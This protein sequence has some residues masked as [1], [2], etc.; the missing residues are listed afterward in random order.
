MVAQREQRPDRL[1]LVGAARELDR[2]LEVLARLGG[3]ADAAED[4]PEDAMRAAGRARLAEALR[5]P[6]RLLGRV[7]GE[8]VVARV[9]V[10]PRR[11]LV[12]A[13]ELEAGRAVLQQVR[14]LLVVVERLL[15]VALVPQRSADLAVEV[16]H[17]PQV[18]L[19]AV[20]LEALLPDLDRGVDAAHAERDVALL[21]VDA[22]E[23]L[24]VVRVLDVARGLVVL[25]GLGVRVQERRSVARG[26]EEVQRLA[27]ERLELELRKAGLLREDRGA[28]VVLGQHRDHLVGAVA[29]A[30][31]DEAPDL[32]VLSAAHRLREHPV[33][34]VADEHVLEG[35]LL[36]TRQL[37]AH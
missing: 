6:Q 12:E 28:A 2:P 22:R 11:L 5:E 26:L 31:L 20:E 35:V 21:L 37:A 4:A 25:E 36:L 24:R 9:H 8:H 1:A 23:R 34:D 10:E 27:V 13:H 32:E 7:D 14:A 16:A 30:L 15:A 17:P 3:V 18:L 29:H 19:R 33:R